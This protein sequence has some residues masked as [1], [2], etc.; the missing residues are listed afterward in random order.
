V[1]SRGLVQVAKPAWD[2]PFVTV[3][4]PYPSRDGPY[5]HRPAYPLRGGDPFRGQPGFAWMD[6]SCLGRGAMGGHSLY[7]GCPTRS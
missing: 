7:A 5:P 3:S 4:Y 6:P 2:Q 1:G